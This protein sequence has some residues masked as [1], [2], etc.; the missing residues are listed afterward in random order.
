MILFY[1]DQKAEL[2]ELYYRRYTGALDRFQEDNPKMGLLLSIAG[3]RFNRGTRPFFDA[4]TPNLHSIARCQCPDLKA[5]TREPD[6]CLREKE[7]V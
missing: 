4:A 6:F 7:N 1:Q 2:S 3:F 5:A